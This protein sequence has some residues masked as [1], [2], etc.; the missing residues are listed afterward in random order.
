MSETPNPPGDKVRRNRPFGPFLLFLTILIVVLALFGSDQLGRR[1]QLT[2][3]QFEAKLYTGQIDKL[4]FKGSSEIEGT[5]KSPA[6]ARFQVSFSNHESRQEH[7]QQLNAVYKYREITEAQLQTAVVGQWYRPQLYRHLTFIKDGH[8]ESVS[9]EGTPEVRPGT[10]QTDRLFVQVTARSEDAYRDENQGR[11]GEF[12]LMEKDS[13]SL[14]IEVTEIEDLGSLKDDLAATGATAEELAF[15]LRKDHG[16]S[17]GAASASVAQILL[18]Y[19][20]WILIIGVFVLFMRQMR[21]QGSGAGVMSFGRSRAQLY[22]K[23]DNTNTTF[24]DVAGAQEA[25][26]EV[27]EVVEFLKNPGRFTRIGGRIPRGVML[28]GPPG[29]GKTLIAKAIAGEAE[30][31]FY[32]ISGSDFVEMFVGVGA[33]RVRDLFK[34][35]RENSPCIIFLDEIDAVGRRRGSGMGGGHD[36]REQTLNAILV[37]MDGFGTDEGIIVVAATNRPDVLDPALLRPG[38]FDREVTIDLPDLEGRREILRV[39]LK[40]V[41]IDD[42]VDVETL[43]RSTPGYSGADLAAITN[44]A[45]I[46]AVLNKQELISMQNLEE[47]ASK[48]RFGREKTSKKIEEEDRKITAYHEAGHTVVGA[49]IEELDPPHKVTIVP[50]GRSLGSTMML[51]LKESYHMQKKR[52]LG[53]LAMLFGG[54]VAEEIFCGDIS[55]GA[56]DDIKRATELARAMITELGMGDTVGPINFAD[57][58]GSDFLGTELMASKW[59]SEATA[60]IIDQEIETIIL[61]AYKRAKNILL[62]NRDAVERMT[63]ALLLYETVNAGEI[64]SLV[65]GMPVADMR[66]EPEEEPE[67]EPVPRA[68]PSEGNVSDPIPDGSELSGGDMPGEAGFSPA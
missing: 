32:S 10:T 16:T 56:S 31:P 23:E 28:V 64:A 2:Q 54:R 22:A 40:K 60:Q 51:P 52:L 11:P 50:R 6:D 68:A 35:A 25:K 17:H 38:R 58:Q 47:A 65:G 24:D 20:P 12:P 55:A 37:E 27:R 26:Q 49:L 41:K 66:P 48:V 1:E 21:N 63:E 39:H 43:A 67:P 7:Y 30:V 62:E 42:Q 44:E 3:D 61:A 5:L 4:E 46:M 36:E 59:H 29:C 45:A 33:S 53:Q 8:E 13:G 57:R 14:W 9:T 34:Q 15:D 18:I 19:G